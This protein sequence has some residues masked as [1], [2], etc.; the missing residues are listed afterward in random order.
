MLNVV[1][2]DMKAFVKIRLLFIILTDIRSVI[3]KKYDDLNFYR[4][5]VPLFSKN[6]REK[7]PKLTNSGT[8]VR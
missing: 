2:N 1:K 7:Q 5:Y 4:T 8:Y 6:R 3:L